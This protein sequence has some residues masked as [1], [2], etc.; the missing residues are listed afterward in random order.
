MVKRISYENESQSVLDACI[1]YLD[2]IA[3]YLSDPQTGLPDPAPLLDARFPTSKIASP[4]AFSDNELGLDWPTIAATIE[5]SSTEN[6]R[7]FDPWYFVV[8]LLLELPGGR[9]IVHT[10]N[11]SK[12]A[13]LG[14]AGSNKSDHITV[15][16][17]VANT[18]R[19]ADTIEMRTHHDLRRPSLRFV[20]KDVR[21]I[22][23][24]KTRGLSRGRLDAVARALQLFREQL[25]LHGKVSSRSFLPGIEL[26][27]NKGMTAANYASLLD[28]AF[29]LADAMH[30][31]YSLSRPLKVGKEP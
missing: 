2:G 13:Y 1:G 14:Y 15:R 5:D 22:L 31:Q 11:H 18:P 27:P 28:A 26:A 10:S 30:E 16:R 23:G 3:K 19:W 25:K 20:S 9:I 4:A 17:I 12:Y 8:L 24:F 7:L 21:T 29:H 6:A